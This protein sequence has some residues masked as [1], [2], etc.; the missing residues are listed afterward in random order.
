MNTDQRKR[1]LAG[2]YAAIA[3]IKDNSPVTDE[4]R[5][6]H[7]LLVQRERER[8]ARQKSLELT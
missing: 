6:Q 5:R 3:A 4:E 1:A 8:Q 2:I 7:D